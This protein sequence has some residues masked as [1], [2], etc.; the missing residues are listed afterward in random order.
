MIPTE[1]SK[2]KEITP[3]RRAAIITMHE[4]GYQFK[5]IR[6]CTGVAI[7]TAS[8]IHRHTP[9]QKLELELELELKLEQELELE[10]ELEQ[11]PELV[12]E[13]E[14][15]PEL[16]LGLGLEPGPELE[17]AEE[18]ELEPELEL[19]EYEIEWPGGGRMLDR[20]RIQR[21]RKGPIYVWESETAEEQEVAQLAIALMEE[22]QVEEEKRLNEEWRASEE[23]EQLRAME[24]AAFSTQCYAEK[25]YNAPK[26]VEKERESIPG[27][28]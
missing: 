5:E 22:E 24:T 23:W 9:E 7:S 18:L 15:E 11:E 1:N 10:L 12:L 20:T 25:H 21:T 16:G 19:E 6:V 28:M 13:L 2:R 8:D 3:C 14:L 26:H 4:L 17:L 27:I